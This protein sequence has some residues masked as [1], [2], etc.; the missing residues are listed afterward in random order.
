MKQRIRRS[1]LLV[2]VAA[3][4]LAQTTPEVPLSDGRG[5]TGQEDAKLPSGKSQ[6][7]EMLKA[8]YAENRKEASQLLELAQQLHGDLE[9]NSQYVFSLSDLKKA[10]EIEKL[11]RKIRGRM[12]PH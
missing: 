11:A 3:V 5:H 2:A 9:K 10:E 6:R 12:Q 7:G 8:E 4:C 1:T